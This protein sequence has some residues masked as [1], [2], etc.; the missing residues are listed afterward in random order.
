VDRERQVR[1][2]GLGLLHGLLDAKAIAEVAGEPDPIETLQHRG[3]LDPMDATALVHILDSESWPSGS[4]APFRAG[5]GVAP[6][7][8]SREP[9]GQSPWD[10]LP[11][12]GPHSDGSGRQVLRAL[13]LPAWKHY[14]DLVFVAEG[15]M[16][17][18][19]KAYDPSLKRAVALKF[20]RRDDPEMAARFAQEAQHQAMVE[21]PRICRV[22]EVGEWQGQSYI[23]MQYV[24][25]ETLDAAIPRLSLTE[26]VQVMEAVAEAIHAAHHARLIHRD[27]KPANII[28][29]RRGGTLEPTI[30]DFGLAKGMDAEGLTQHGQAMGSVHY[31]APEQ[32]RGHHDRINRRTDVYGLGA[33][34]HK[35]LTGEPPFGAFEGVEVF[36]RTVETDVPP[37]RRLVPDLP[38]DLDTL[39]RKCLE[40]DPA[41]RYESALAVAEDLRRWREGEPILARKPTLP[42]LAMKWAKRHKLVMVVGGV[43]LVGLLVLAGLALATASSARTQ[44]RHAQHFGQEAER[45]EALMRY[46]HLL[47]PHD[48]R[49]MLGQARA[50]MAAL[51]AEARRAGRLA[52]GPAAYAL[53]R[54]HLA[55][56]DQEQARE[57]LEAAWSSGLHTPE[58][59]LALGRALAASYQRALD[60]ARALPSKELQEA[61]ERE[62]ARD[63]R[64]PAL[65][66]LREGTSAALES[67]A[68]QEALIAFMG[69][70]WE[71]AQT[72]AREALTAT[73]WLFEAKRLEGEALLARARALQD[74]GAALTCLD[75][76][77]AAFTEARQLGPSDPATALGLV[78][79]L[80]ERTV[81]ELTSGGRGEVALARCREA[82]AA[83]RT[84]RPDEG[85]APAHLARALTL[86]A[87]LHPPLEAA[88]AAAYLEASSLSTEALA[89]GPDDPAIQAIRI[90]VLMVVAT[91][92]LRPR[93]I[94]PLSAYGESQELAR[95]AQQRHPEEP[96]FTA[97]LASA[98]MRR[99]TW[100]INAGI[101]PWASFE[102]GLAQAL[103]LRNRFPDFI[104]GFQALATLWVERAE[105]ERLHGLDPRPSVA[106]ALEAAAGARARGLRQRSPGWTEGD[107]HLIQGQYLLVTQGSG[108]GDFLQ[109][110]EGYQRALQANPNLLQAHD[111]LAEATL[112]RAQERLERGLD[113]DALIQEAE[114]HLTALGSRS[115][116]PGQTHHLRG[117]ATLLRGRQRLAQGLDPSPVWRQAVAAFRE[118]A[119][120]AGHAKA[121]VGEAEA[122]AR[123][124]RHRGLPQDRAQALAAAQ[125]ALAQDPQ[126]AEAWLWIAVA[127]QEAVRRGRRDSE[128]PAREAWAKAL[129]I[130]ANLRRTALSLGMP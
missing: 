51:E 96:L 22:Y 130:D 55:L 17:R 83:A 112:G 99:M 94:D 105:Y 70:Q 13:T 68:Y 52:T 80:S 18:V 93:G 12:A 62:L 3:L 111:S 43:A 25:G 76:A 114:A 2:L 79:A 63:L 35:V 53:G 27:L 124:Y 117:M 29:A 116:A 87:D 64:D 92:Y 102:E 57:R 34:L 20:L 54:S 121:Q 49:P 82:V 30:L 7:S 119:K 85:R 31:M 97:I 101:P 23:A 14:R 6:F 37:L 81:L 110:C 107:A 41:R 100:E 58:V 77:E 47:P 67:P 75:Q 125:K 56:G 8:G 24:E 21:H 36:R 40:K 38:A 118:A 69:G 26:K 95:A 19:F 10:S 109:A 45:I 129:T 104:G 50:R 59:S 126:R 5:S 42:Y 103:S 106:A 84:L 48:V 15:G 115:P 1:L 11:Q 122:W 78:Q 120:T 66:H 123:A 72:K 86:W 98:C 61:R 16:G 89:L 74:P 127:E 71:T 65:A 28:V 4:S 33:S 108:E 39:T 88:T 90:P 73:P 91:R 60:L 32:V 9:G 44:V 128:A 46:S 113:P